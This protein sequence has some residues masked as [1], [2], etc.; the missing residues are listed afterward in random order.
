MRN[1]ALAFVAATGAA[2]GLNA[3]ELELP[4]DWIL[5]GIIVLACLHGSDESA[6]TSAQTPDMRGI[7]SKAR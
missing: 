1:M 5:I 3:A 6:A 4:Y 7:R 2:F